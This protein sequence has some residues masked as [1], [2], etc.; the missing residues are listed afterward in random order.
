MKKQVFGVLATIGMLLGTVAGN[1]YGQGIA[2]D[3]EKA[4]KVEAY[5]A[6][7][8]K[9]D[10]PGC[11]IGAIKNGNLVYKR[12]FG[13][14]N[15][16]YDIPNTPTTLF[17]IAS[18][19]KQFTA[20]SV[21]LLVQQGKLSL[22]DDIR[23]YLPEMPDY[24]DTI[25]IRHLLNHTSGI[26]EYQAVA[27]FSGQ[28]SDNAYNEQQIVKM[29]ARQK[30]TNFKPGSKHQYSN[31]GYQLAGTI[32]SRVSGK[33]LRAFADENI[34]KPLGMKNTQ[35]F[36]NRFEVV[37]N[38]A[39]GYMVG[40]QGIRMRSSL[41]DLVGGGGVMTTVEDLLLWDQ[42]FYE[43]KVGNKELIA[44]M[45]TPAV[46]T[47]GDK[48]DYAF[49]LVKTTYKG[50]ITIQHGGNMSGFRA[51][52]SRYPDQKFTAL[53]MCNNSARNQFEITQKLADIYLEGQFPTAPTV[54]EKVTSAA[55]P[56]Q[57]SETESLK[58]T[59]IFAR[60]SDGFFI[61]IDWKDGKLT[62][63]GMFGNKLTVVPVAGGRLQIV[64]GKNIT[65][66]V[67]VLDQS[68]TASELKFLQ[69]GGGH[70]SFQRVKPADASPEK[71]VEFAGTYHSDELGVDYQ[72]SVQGN[73]LVLQISENLRPTLNPGYAD[74][75][76]A[77]AGLVL[78]FSRD[79]KGKITG[80]VF[81]SGIDDR[82]VKGVVFK[83][84]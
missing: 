39:A 76:F 15:L 13:L 63:S 57:L 69:R 51:Q 84:K 11:A 14:A 8:D 81:N 41:F 66:I 56:L 7:W 74:A 17:T 37:K 80:F 33:S 30:R 75:F 35:Y 18:T 5:I 42:N 9:P 2:Q 4:K 25:T 16:D 1:V 10:Q 38:R 62:T 22:D 79:E 83:R 73:A 59:G 55:A 31:S 12:G 58:Y 49:G 60:T 65:E 52:I 64:D 61:K 54:D 19:S 36:D 26:R 43:P 28:G 68:G 23:K 77:P 72:V 27:M 29:L 53:A 24:G 44:L 67:P 3:D 21:L 46:L 45:T 20:M 70:D 32:V 6:P 34:F 48:N 78:P 71:L 82:D 50:L 47:G 40:P